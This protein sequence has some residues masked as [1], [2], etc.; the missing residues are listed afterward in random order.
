MKIAVWSGLCLLVTATA[1]IAFSAWNMKNTANTQRLEAIQ[2]AK[3]L[4]AASAG[5][6]AI[7][8]QTQLDSAMNVARTLA[9]TFSGIKDDRAKLKLDRDALNNTLKIILQKNSNFVGTYTAWEPDELDGL[10]DLYKGTEGHDETGR[11]IPYW[12]RDEDGKIVMKPLVDYEKEGAGD[13]YFLPKKTKTECIVDPYIYPVQGKP[14]LITS[15]VVPIIVGETFYGIVG[16]DL[17]LDF[18][19]EIANNVKDLYDGA[20]RIM[21]ISHNGTLAAVTNKPDLQ[22]MH[23]KEVNKNFSKELSEVQ[24]GKSKIQTNE[25]GELE[26][27]IPLGAGRSKTPWS[28]KISIPEQ[29][30]T[31]TADMQMH[32]GVQNMWKMMAISTVCVLAALILMWFVARNIARPINRV[33]EDLNDGAGQVSSASGQI[34]SSSQ[35]L[36]EGASEQAASI[37]ETSSSLEEMSSMTKQNADTPDRRILS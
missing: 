5:Q 32:T 33:I 2:A 24:S 29:K 16:I 22:G 19:Q 8:A 21:I 7:Q 28:V 25:K 15:L 9:E 20:A 3:Q 11:F 18:L 17:R 27:F 10:D 35:Q 13:Y 31:F 36:A 34:S 26:V 1:I 4:A 6:K 30:V 23:M 14:T 37:E 12:N